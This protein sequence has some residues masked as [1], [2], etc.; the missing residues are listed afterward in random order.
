MTANKNAGKHPSYKKRNM[1]EKARKN[2]IAYDK[3]LN[4]K[5]EQVK[6]RMECNNA[7]RKAKTNGK[8][9]NGKDAS[10]TENGI[11]FK[12]TKA[13]RGS[14]SDSKGDKNARGGK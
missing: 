2:K 4:A 1:S 7:R 6:K 14:K 8:D 13:N 12:S 11:V 5:P 3:E 10:H 9:V